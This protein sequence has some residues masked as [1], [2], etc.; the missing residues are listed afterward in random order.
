MDRLTPGT[1]LRRGSLTASISRHGPAIKLGPR[2]FT[3][4]HLSSWTSFLIC[5]MGMKS[6]HQY[7]W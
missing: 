5:K 3:R 4:C 7:H 2:P 1:H 6:T